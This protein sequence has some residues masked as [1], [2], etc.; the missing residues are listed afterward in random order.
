MASNIALELCKGLYTWTSV[1]VIAVSLFYIWWRRP[2]NFPPGPRGLPLI[3][4]LPFLGRF[5]GEVF[6]KWSLEYGPVMSIRMGR[7]DVVV[8]N[9]GDSFREAFV[10]QG[11]NTSGRPPDIMF[12]QVTGDKGLVFKDYSAN[13]KATKKWIL[14]TLSQYGLGRRGMEEKIQEE[15]DCLAG[16]LRTKVGKPV[17]FKLSLYCLTSNVVSLIMSGRR[18]DYED[19]EHQKRLELIHLI[20]GDPND[21]P[22][23][24]LIDLFPALKYLP[25]FKTANDKLRSRMKAVLGFTRS[26]IEEHKK[27]FEKDDIRDF[28][29]TFLAE[30]KFGNETSRDN[31]T[32]DELNVLFRDF[33]L[34]GSETTS[35]NI[36]WILLLLVHYP[37]HTAKVIKEIDTIIGPNASA[38]STTHSSQMPFTCA[39]I[40]ES[41]RYRTSVPLGAQHYCQKTFQ[42]NGYTIPKGTLIYP[43]IWG[44]HNDPKSWPNP[45]KFD[46]YRHIDEKGNYRN[47][48][49]VIPFLIGPRNCVGEALARQEI[50]IFLVKILQKFEVKPVPG[51]TPSIADGVNSV[52][53]SPHSFNLI[54]QER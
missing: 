4:V 26:N 54:L 47:S 28:I 49:N 36:L 1:A 3:G 38:S 50:F 33:F 53:F 52:V 18:Y 5:P 23:L 15:A 31:F 7:S 2:H 11:A 37:E 19:E 29:D 16:Y 12:A 21:A 6:K 14:R 39:F 22:K 17:D 40:Q 45:S 44:V 10:E 35:T 43:N 51:K 34:A 25:V 20:F 41:M 24:L 9:T 13:F 8:V 27:T 30:M 32:E 42:L 48:S 46:P